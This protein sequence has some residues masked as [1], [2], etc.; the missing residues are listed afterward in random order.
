MK[1]NNTEKKTLKRIAHHLDCIVTVGDK[2]LSES[3]VAETN[4]ALDD[5]ELIKVRIASS[6]RDDREN[7]GAEL[8]KVCK[9]EIVQRIGK[10]LIL[11]KPNPKPNQKLSNLHRFSGGS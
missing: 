3:V 1:S 10:V 2:G 11:F 9:A 5:H 7:T 6:E 4:R 8:A